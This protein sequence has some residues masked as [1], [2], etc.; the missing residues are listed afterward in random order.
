MSATIGEIGKL[1][2]YAAVPIQWFD[3]RPVNHGVAF[4][5]L[6]DLFRVALTLR[7]QQ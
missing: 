3:L 7:L 1:K 2:R 6:C 5:Q 4:T